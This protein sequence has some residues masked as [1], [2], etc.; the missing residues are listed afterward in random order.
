MRG[1]LINS[2]RKTIEEIDG[3][4][5][6]YEEINRALGCE[7]MTTGSRPLRGDIEQGFDAVYVS[8]DNLEDHDDPRF[9]FQVDADRN[10]PSSF[11]IAGNGFER[12]CANLEFLLTQKR[13]KLGGKF[14]DIN[15]FLNSIRLDKFRAIAEQRKRIA[16]L[17]KSEEPKASNRQIARTLG[18]DHKTVSSDLGGNSPTASKKDRQAKLDLAV[19]GENSPPNLSGEHSVRST[20]TQPRSKTRSARNSFALSVTR[21][22]SR[23]RA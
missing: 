17:I 22:T 5:E 4:F 18:V 14:K 11:P 9:W 10:P 2:E 1:H 6:D 8:D 13:W 21:P 3:A 19:D 7:S 23:R 15:A 20:I 16:N 12:A